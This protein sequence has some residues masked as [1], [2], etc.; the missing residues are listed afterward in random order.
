MKKLP[1]VLIGLLAWFII[2][3]FGKNEVIWDSTPVNS[4]FEETKNEV[5]SAKITEILKS[6]ENDNADE[7]VSQINLLTENDGTEAVRNYLNDFAAYYKS[8]K[9]HRNITSLL[10]NMSIIKNYYIKEGIDEFSAISRSEVIP[11]FCIK[12]FELSVKKPKELNGICN[13]YLLNT[14]TNHV[15]Q[16][17]AVIICLKVRSYY[18]MEGAGKTNDYIEDVQKMITEYQKY[19]E[20]GR[21][22]KFPEEAAYLNRF[23]KLCDNIRNKHVF[24]KFDRWT[25]NM[26]ISKLGE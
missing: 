1:F 2:F 12:N 10:N 18:K 13:S 11:F 8:D 17:S 14:L 7:A 25:F 15:S 23:L 26:K 5:S 20:I 16:Y 22:P 24:D 19:D 9:K 21:N 3:K 6:L 4:L